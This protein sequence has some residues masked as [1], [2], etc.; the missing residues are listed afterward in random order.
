MIGH[1]FPVAL[2][3]RD[4][5]VGYRRKRSVHAVIERVNVAAHHGQL[6]CLLGAN[7]IG[8]TTLLRTLAAM[9]PPL[10]GHVEM[11]GRDIRAVSPLELARTLAIVLTDR[12]AI[13]GL[14]CRRVVELGRYPHT[15]WFGRVAQTDRRIV[16]RMIDAVG[17][18]HLAHRDVSH[19]SD[20][21]RQRVMIG[22][23]LAQQPSVLILD[24][25]TAFLDVPSRVE[26]MALLRD[27][28]RREH[29]AVI[30]SSH[31][32][33]LAVR[34]ADV[35]WLVMPGGELA[36]GAPEDVML[37]GA[38][39]DAFAGSGLRFDL[40][41]RAFRPLTGHRGQAIV[42]G[43]GIRAS[44]AASVLEREGYSPGGQGESAGVAVTVDE[45]GW[46]AVIHN[47]TSRG[48]D[49]ASLAASLRERSST[50]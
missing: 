18:G 39:A 10:A 21:E 8:K 35:I 1:P 9:H 22:R 40:T 4:L 19:L 38:I 25:P 23:A 28:S 43:S 32:L 26:L 13:E 27:L 44:L 36:T 2:R 47:H 3:T 48:G 6:V 45:T 37:S 46:Q 30:V 29:V 7:G 5:T 41:D 42:R 12:A 31:D 11:G 16:D 49:F 33:E 17:V 15:G 20:G 34:V 50:P 24:E 14:T